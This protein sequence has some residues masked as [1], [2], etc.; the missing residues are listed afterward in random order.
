MRTIDDL[1]EL[2]TAAGRELEGAPA[3]EIVRWA[4]DTFGAR[5]CVTS[6]FADAVLVH[7]VSRVVPGV[8]VVFLDT[9]LHFPE[10]LRVRDQAAAS[11]PV[12]VRSIR[13]RLTVGQQDGAYG[14]RLFSRDPD[15]CCALRKVEPLERAL[16]D[17]DAWA[18]G[19]RR[20]ESRTR[21][22]TP[23]VH[24]EYAR[25]KVKVNPLASWT[26]SDVDSYIARY[27]VPV[28]SLLRR[29]YGSVGCWPCTR[30][31]TAGEDPRAGRWAMFDKAECG[32]H[33]VT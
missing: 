4:A 17:Y 28:N 21:A 20:D 15:E 22:N 18:A 3:E 1:T 30:R 6:S 25:N 9:G 24:F 13:P 32:L 33:T 7:L 27:D 5:F 26:Q 11:L 8:D 14:P 10:T 16:D 19:L 31:T 12:H 29:G 2:A 23:V